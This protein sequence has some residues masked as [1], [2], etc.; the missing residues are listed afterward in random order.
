MFTSSTD[1]S[2]LATYEC[3][4]VIPDN[5]RAAQLLTV[6]GSR[7]VDLGDGTSSFDLPN[8]D[9]T[10]V[11]DSGACRFET[12][13]ADPSVDSQDLQFGPTGRIA[14]VDDRSF[15]EVFQ[16]DPYLT[17]PPAPCT[18]Q[19]PLQFTPAIDGGEP[20]LLVP[21]QMVMK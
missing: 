5:M 15:I 19:W 3:N 6:N 21:C 14:Y 7:F 9:V 8:S 20:M 2:R 11:Y 16:G 10:V 18:S 12:T 4:E 1:G 13:D 17:V